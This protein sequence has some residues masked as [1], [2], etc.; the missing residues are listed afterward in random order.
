MAW[1]QY[2]LIAT[3]MA[4]IVVIARKGPA[5]RNPYRSSWLYW[6]VAETTFIMLCMSW[7]LSVP[8]ALWFK[9]K[10]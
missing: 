8:L 3:Y 7:P 5:D 1:W 2:I 10:R 6:M 9:R 4:G